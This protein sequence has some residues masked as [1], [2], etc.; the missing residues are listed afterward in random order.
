[1]ANWNV[2]QMDCYP[3]VD[4]EKDVV[5][6]IHYDCTETEGDYSGRV[7]GTVGVTLDAGAPFTPY[8]DLTL[9]QV[10]GWVKGALSEETVAA[11]EAN[12]LQQIADQKNPPV[13]RPPLPWAAAA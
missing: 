9:D 1:M 3:K 8:A 10:I 4:G 6:T 5:F 11:T 12:V 2:S 7:Y 13:V